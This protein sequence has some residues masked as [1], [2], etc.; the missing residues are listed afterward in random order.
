MKVRQD[1]IRFNKELNFNDG[2]EGSLRAFQSIFKKMIMYFE[3]VGFR[4]R[5]L[6]VNILHPKWKIVLI[7]GNKVKPPSLCPHLLWALQ[8]LLQ[9]QAQ[10]VG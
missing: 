3:K 2:V 8:P 7:T 5:K 1:L 10:L 6:Q 9:L 4:L